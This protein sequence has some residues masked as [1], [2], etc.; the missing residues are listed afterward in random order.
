MQYVFIIGSHPELSTD[1]VMAVVPGA[2]LLKST[3][4]YCVI[5]SAPI[6]CEAILNRMGGTIKIAQVIGDDVTPSVIAEHL[7]H[8][9]GKVKFGISFYGRT[10]AR[11]SL[12]MEVK[13][14]LRQDG[15]SSRLVTS[16]QKALSSVII[17]KNKVQ[18]FVVIDDSLL[19]VTQAVQDFR[20]YSKR[21][22][23]RPER[24]MLSGSMPPKLAQIMLNLSEKPFNAVIV[25][26]FCG[27]G[28]MLQEAVL[29]G[30]KNVSG[31]DVSQ[32]AVD[33]SKKNLEWLQKEFVESEIIMPN[34]SLGDVREL[35]TNCAQH[36]VDAIV[37]EPYL[38]P[39]LKGNESRAEIQKN[40]EQLTDL[41]IA[42]FEQFKTVLKDDGVIVMIVPQFVYK[43]EI[44]QLPIFRKI[45]SLGFEQLS[46]DDWVFARDDH[47]AQRY[48][49]KWKIK[50]SV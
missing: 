41:F 29:M 46:K 24:D 26:P 40:I 8:A 1:E 23:G 15:V 37:S 28:T 6:D 9:T 35:N 47:K 30:F 16:Q 48:I 49:G 3:S 14:L 31:F 25:D 11:K 18:D 17:T 36:S 12:G 7:A 21:D 50:K 4:E 38:G 27:S 45:E 10:A 44:L 43:R 13:A 34:V 19:A 2:T 32:K 22:F 20:A 42:T 39:P 33:D 5:E